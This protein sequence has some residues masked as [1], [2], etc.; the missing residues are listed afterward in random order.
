ME[1]EGFSL[2]VLEM[3]NHDLDGDRFSALE[4]RNSLTGERLGEFTMMYYTPL[5]IEIALPCEHNGVMYPY[6]GFSS[7]YLDHLKVG[8]AFLFFPF[9]LVLSSIII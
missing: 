2:A 5:E 9:L 8:F 1:G 4:F 3:P 6:V 7:V